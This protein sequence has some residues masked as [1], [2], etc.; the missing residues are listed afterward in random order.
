M[1]SIPKM[2]AHPRAKSEIFPGL[3]DLKKNPEG[4]SQEIQDSRTGKDLGASTGIG[5]ERN[6]S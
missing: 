6:L 5:N 2:Y 1:S 4:F 3:T